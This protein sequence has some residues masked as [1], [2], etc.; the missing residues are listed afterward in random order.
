[1]MAC[2][3]GFYKEVKVMLCPQFIERKEIVLQDGVKKCGYWLKEKLMY[4]KFSMTYS[5]IQKFSSKYIY[6]FNSK[7]KLF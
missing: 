6:I 2:L 5:N 1:M 4:T 7:N 3:I